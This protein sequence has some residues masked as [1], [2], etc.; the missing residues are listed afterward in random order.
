MF[1]ELK[2]AGVFEDPGLMD[3]FLGL[4]NSK[5]GGN[6]SWWEYINRPS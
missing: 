1:G 6:L 4:G 2:G 3:E 5:N